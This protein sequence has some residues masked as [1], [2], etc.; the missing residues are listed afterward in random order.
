MKATVK[1]L[2]VRNRDSDVALSTIAAW[3]KR[4]INE[5]VQFFVIPSED[6][7]NTII[8]FV[9]DQSIDLLAMTTYKRGFFS[10]LFRTHFTER[11]TYHSDTPIL[12]L[13]E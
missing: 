5:P 13:H 8:D 2:Y 6:I 11:M 10:E 3:E 1:C 4:F 7:S 9:A 12:V